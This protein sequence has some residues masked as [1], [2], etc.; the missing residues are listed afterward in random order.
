MHRTSI[1]ILKE[2]GVIKIYNCK[3]FCIKNYSCIDCYH[4]K[5][6]ECKPT[7]KEDRKVCQES[8]DK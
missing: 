4:R 7:R 8:Q 5:I 2:P 3:I 6:A 1:R